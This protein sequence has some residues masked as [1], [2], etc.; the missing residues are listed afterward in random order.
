MWHL[1]RFPQ[2]PGSIWVVLHS[3]QFSW[4]IQKNLFKTLYKVDKN[5]QSF[6]GDINVIS[7]SI[8]Y[9]IA[10]I[11][12]TLGSVLGMKHLAKLRN[13]N[14]PKEILNSSLKYVGTIG[15]FTAPTLLLNSYFAAAQKKG[16]RISDMI[17]MKEMEDYRFFADYSMKFLL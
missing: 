1:F 14:S 17:T 6:S 10:L 9:P 8:K 11:L 2:M 16:A 3:N 12:G 7:E 15:L 5:S 13:A 4:R